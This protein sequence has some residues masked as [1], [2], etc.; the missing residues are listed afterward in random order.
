MRKIDEIKIDIPKYPKLI[1][2]TLEQNGYEAYIVGGCVR[3][4]LL[5]KTP[6]DYDITTNATPEVIKKLFKR[7]IDVGIKHG[8]VSVLFYEKDKPLTFEVT[9]YRIDGEYDDARHPKKVLFVNDL[10][11]DLL[12]RDFTINAMAYNEKVGLVDEFGGLVDLERKIIRA[13]GNPEERFNEDALRLLRAIRFSAKLGFDIEEDTRNAII[14]LASYLSLIS[15]ERIQVELTKTITSD[16][17][18]YISKVYEYGLAK[19]IADGFD[20]VDI[21]RFEK[22]QMIHIAYAC[23]LYNTEVETAT[24]ILRDL[25]LD[26]STISKV[27]SLIDAKRI[28]YAICSSSEDRKISFNLCVKQLINFL[29]YELASDFI[30]LVEINENENS[31]INDEIKNKVLKLKKEKCPIF[32]ADLMINGNDLKD[33]GFKGQEIGVGLSQLLQIVHKNRKCNKK[34]VLQEIAKKAYNTYKGE[35]YEL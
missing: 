31:T 6:N 1:I 18:S 14:K 16:N 17:P 27:L 34:N 5:G 32:I 26:N 35:Q 12:R 29:G 13:V 25:K 7:T 2:D 11:E 4:N 9:T 19:Y 21:G 24:K 15:K 22:R 23:L 33:I 10:R 30:R 8:T 3:D 20:K 28:Y